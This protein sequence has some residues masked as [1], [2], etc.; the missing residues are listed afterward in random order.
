MPERGGLRVL[1]STSPS[2]TRST[3]LLRRKGRSSFCR[4]FLDCSD[5]TAGVLAPSLSFSLCKKEPDDSCRLSAR[6]G[7]G[8]PGEA[9]CVPLAPRPGA[10]PGLQ[11]RSPRPFDAPGR[12]LVM[13]LKRRRRER[14]SSASDGWSADTGIYPRTP[15][16]RSESDSDSHAQ[17]GPGHPTAVLCG[18]AERAGAGGRLRPR[19]GIRDLAGLF[20]FS[21]IQNVC[22]HPRK[23][24][25]NPLFF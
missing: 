8:T 21:K 9:R 17:K 10:P 5:S 16:S 11:L 2:R 22:A 24:G 15:Q 7:L 23:T 14:G 4:A 3:M 12:E 25:E 20:R 18:C 13:E 1:R 6:G 19:S